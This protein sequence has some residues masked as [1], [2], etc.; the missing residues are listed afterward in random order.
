MTD[1][2]DQP[3][4]R[5]GQGEAV[6]RRFV[7]PLRENRP[8]P[9][10]AFGLLGLATLASL[11]YCL[12]VTRGTT[13]SGDELAW[14]ALSPGM[15]LKEA[16]EPHSGHLV[17]VSH[18][19]YKF[20]LET[21]GS[22]YL[23]FRLLTLVTVYLSVWM[24]FIWA[25]RRVGDFVA[26]APCLVLLFFGTDTGHLLQGNGFTIM[27]AIAC[28]MLALLG[29]ERNSRSGDLVAC[30]A[31]CLGVLTYTVVLAFLV[32]AV[33][34]VLVSDRRWSRIWVVAIPVAI[35]LGWRIWVL[36]GDI[37]ITRG[38]VEPGYIVLLPAWT[39]QSLSGILNALSGLHLS[40][41]GGGWLPPG[42]M[43]GP[44]LALAFLVA[45]GW[46]ITRGGLNRWFWVAMVIAL[47][48]FASQVLSWIPDVREP[49]TSR[50][51]FPGAFVVLLVAF[52]AARG[53]RPTRAAFIAIWIVA[54]TGF[55][56]NASIIKNSGDSLR[57]RTPEVKADVTAATLIGDAFPYLPGPDA[58][59]LEELVSAPQIPIIGAAEQEYGGIGYGRS[60]IASQPDGARSR[61]DSIMAQAFG[62]FLVP[63]QGEKPPGCQTETAAGDGLTTAPLPPKGAVLSSKNG[64]TVTIRRFGDGFSTTVGELPETR[65]MTLN[66]PQDSDPTP[67]QIAV[68]TPRLTV[69]PLTS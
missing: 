57:E 35:Y 31:L 65:P 53:Y 64:G 14:V 37:D 36:T 30:L 46:R 5:P 67:W 60:E 34:A 25:R 69:C 22:S 59:P 18:L 45:I 58:K 24:L 33:F 3:L 66:V 61:I 63:Y 4:I 50:Y 48:M 12:F 38:G 55:A 32:G 1:P 21:V 39:Y 15:G 2:T 44:T 40:F 56:T 8:G 9:R 41:S 47:A 51:L 62:F 6:M 68:R 19:L 54:L 43:A 26:L 11:V 10:L 13:F 7:D 52:E 49:G 28:G 27:L 16:L 42:A 23:I 17:L 20:I 29:L